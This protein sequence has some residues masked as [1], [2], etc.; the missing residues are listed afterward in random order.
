VVRVLASDVRPRESSLVEPN[1][2]GGRRSDRGA[3][4]LTTATGAH[5]RASAD[6][7][8]RRLRPVHEDGRVH[9]DAAVSLPE[10]A[11][12]PSRR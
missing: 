7:G 6:N 3:N 1:T 4:R 2:F 5:G 10:L 8:A 9:D 11:N 12:T